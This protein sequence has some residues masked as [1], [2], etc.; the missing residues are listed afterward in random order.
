MY[1]S[2]NIEKGFTFEFDINSLLLLSFELM[3]V[4]LFLSLII[5]IVVTSNKKFRLYVWSGSDL[6]ALIS[7]FSNNLN[8]LYYIYINKSL[9]F[10]FL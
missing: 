10:G 4:C 3:S 5:L 7:L 8:K 6:N 2:N 1:L 9:L